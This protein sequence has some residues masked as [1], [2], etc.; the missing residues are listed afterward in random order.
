MIATAEEYSKAQG[1]LQRLESWLQRLQREHPVP[2]KGLTKTG[3]RKM[4]SRLHEE[5]AVYKGGR[6]VEQPERSV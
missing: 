1:E 2:A 4:I 5:L 6:E 3:V